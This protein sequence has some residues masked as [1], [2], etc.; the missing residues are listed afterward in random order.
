MNIRQWDGLLNAAAPGTLQTRLEAS[1]SLKSAQ[2]YSTECLASH[3]PNATLLETSNEC[4][5]I[6]SVDHMTAA[7]A[8]RTRTT[9]VSRAAPGA[10]V[11]AEHAWWLSVMEGHLLVVGRQ[12]DRQAGR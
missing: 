1:N 9:R 11:A 7:S 2:G 6:K 10:A 8:A 12:A 4:Q 3:H 5:L